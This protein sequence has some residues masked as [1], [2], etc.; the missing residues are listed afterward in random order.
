MDG[1][2]TAMTKDGLYIKQIGSNI[3]LG[4]SENFGSGLFLTP[5]LG[6]R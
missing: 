6:Q 5:F 4:P 3:Y 1:N 2:E